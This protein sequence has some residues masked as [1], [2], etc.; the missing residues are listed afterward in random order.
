[1][2]RG[3]HNTVPPAPLPLRVFVAQTLSVGQSC[4]ILLLIF[5]SLPPPRGRLRWRADANAAIYR[6]DILRAEQGSIVTRT[7]MPLSHKQ[8]Q[9]VTM[10]QKLHNKSGELPLYNGHSHSYSAPPVSG[11]QNSCQQEV[12]KFIEPCSKGEKCTY[13]EASRGFP[14]SYVLWLHNI[15]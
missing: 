1:M 10:A 2:E 7:G 13:T 4:L 5:T 9:M 11:K 8:G 14:K 12:I 3:L 6:A 15:Y